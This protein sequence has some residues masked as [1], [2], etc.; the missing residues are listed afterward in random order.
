MTS[1]GAKEVIDSEL[2]KAKE[3]RRAVELLREAGLL[4]EA[5]RSLHFAAFYLRRQ[6]PGHSPI[7]I[8]EEFPLRGRKHHDRHPRMP[9]NQRLHVAMYSPRRHLQP[10]GEF[11]PA[12]AAM[13]L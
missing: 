2:A 4:N 6:Y 8:F 1:E 12:Q 3:A 9:K 10:L 11:T 7:F 5:R 13:G